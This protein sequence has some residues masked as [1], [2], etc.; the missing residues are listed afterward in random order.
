MRTV[1]KATLYR[2][3][4]A[5]LRSIAA[6]WLVCTAGCFIAACGE[7]TSSAPFAPAASAPS[8][9]PVALS[10][11]AGTRGPS[12]KAPIHLPARR[13]RHCRL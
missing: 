6:V 12:C 2:G 5:K 4:L 11:A 9:L 3:A 1:T 8:T 7:G 10:M 13:T